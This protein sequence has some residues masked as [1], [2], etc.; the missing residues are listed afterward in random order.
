MFKHILIATDGSS[1]ATIA[2]RTAVEL[3]K[4]CGATLTGIHVIEP[5]RPTTY[6]E[7]MIPSSETIY[8]DDAREMAGRYLQDVE[9]TASA[10]GV[11][12]H[13]LYEIGAPVHCTIEEAAKARHCDLI[14]V[15]SHGRRGLQRLLLGSETQ[16]I[17]LTTQLPVLVCRTPNPN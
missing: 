4:I 12:C 17:L 10:A 11:R 13:T 6:G 16:K 15:G 3:A 14:V 7:M 5:F 2:T 8:L 9:Q 1:V